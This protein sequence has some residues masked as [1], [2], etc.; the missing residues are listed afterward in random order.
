[1]S[2]DE[3]NEVKRRSFM[4]SDAEFNILNSALFVYYKGTDF[5]GQSII[6]ETEEERDQW[7]EDGKAITNL[8]QRFETEFA[9]LLKPDGTFLLTVYGPKDSDTIVNGTFTAATKDELIAKLQ[10]VFDKALGD[11]E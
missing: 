3:K 7:L 8:G 1:M 9:D 6:A 11:N 10:A 2:E 5:I 4:L